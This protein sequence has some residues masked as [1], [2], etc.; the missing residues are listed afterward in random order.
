MKAARWSAFMQR[1]LSFALGSE[2]RSASSGPRRMKDCRSRGAST[3]TPG[4]FAFHQ[5][6]QKRRCGDDW[7][8]FVHL[9][10]AHLAIALLA[11][12][13]QVGL[14]FQNHAAR[15]VGRF[16]GPPPRG[17]GG[18]SQ[19]ALHVRPMSDNITS[20]RLTIIKSNLPPL[21]NCGAHIHI[22][23]EFL[24]PKKSYRYG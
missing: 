3:A 9:G 12:L 23:L 16:D 20:I 18:S 6:G 2:G 5:S 14:R 17:A 7:F 8:R 21:C 24:T 4:L 1:P 22:S 10:L 19:T 13:G 15:V 11:A